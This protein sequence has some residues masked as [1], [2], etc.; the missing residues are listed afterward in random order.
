[1]S[2]SEEVTSVIKQVLP[3]NVGTD[4]EEVLV[5]CVTHAKSFIY[6]ISIV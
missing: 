2:F 5:S 6:Y 3:Q 1:M 4:T